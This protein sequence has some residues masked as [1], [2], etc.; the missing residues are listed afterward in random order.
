MQLDHEIKYQQS[1]EF[2]LKKNNTKDYIN[3]PFVKM[4]SELKNNKEYMEWGNKN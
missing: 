2:N 1:F 3:S 4:I